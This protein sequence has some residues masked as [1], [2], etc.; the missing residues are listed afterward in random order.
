MIEEESV[1]A[2]SLLERIKYVFF[3]TKIRMK[4]CEC[5]AVALSGKLTEEGISPLV[6]SLTVFFEN[7]ILTGSH[8][9]RKEFGPSDPVELKEVPK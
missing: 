1:I 7:Y 4:A 6:W 3:G 5:A 9:T 8:G 2:D